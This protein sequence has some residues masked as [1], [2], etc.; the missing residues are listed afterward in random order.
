M[1]PSL[2]ALL[3]SRFVSQK[4]IFFISKRS[5]ADL[6]FLKDLIEARKVTPVID[7]SYPLS[8]VPEA[9]R[10]LEEGHARGKV[11]ITV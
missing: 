5:Q 8:D 10:Y 9:I 7:R 6:L 11:V 2:K 4:Q 3:L 1:L